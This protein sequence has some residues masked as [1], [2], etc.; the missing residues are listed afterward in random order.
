MEA[1]KRVTRRIVPIRAPP[2]KPISGVERPSPVLIE[3]N[4]LAMWAFIFILG[5]GR[6]MLVRM[7]GWGTYILLIFVLTLL[8]NPQVVVVDSKSSC[9]YSSALIQM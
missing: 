1:P 7:A 6:G 2:T 4:T 8:E 3:D 9:E 5:F